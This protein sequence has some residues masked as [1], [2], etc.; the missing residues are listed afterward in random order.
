[1]DTDGSGAI[2]YTEFLAATLDKHLYLQEDVCWSAFRPFDRDGDGLISQN[3]LKLVLEMDDVVYACG[4]TTDIAQ[5]MKDFDANGD[6]VIDFH[7]FMTMLR[8]FESF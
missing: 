5:L 6:G 8:G 4:G 2:D 1:M 7:E 3:E